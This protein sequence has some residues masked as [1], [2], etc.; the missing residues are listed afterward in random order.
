LVTVV[1]HSAT[2]AAGEWITAT[3][4][5]VND[6]NMV[7]PVKGPR[8]ET[9]AREMTMT[10]GRAAI[11]ATTYLLSI[12]T[13]LSAGV[14]L[15]TCSQSML[16]GTWQVYFTF[17][18]VCPVAIASHGSVSSGTCSIPPSTTFSLPQPPSGLLTIDRSCHVTGT[19]SYSYLDPDNGWGPPAVS[20]QLIMTL[21]RSADGS[22][23]SGS[24]LL[25]GPNYQPVY[26]PVD[27]IAE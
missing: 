21:W 15:P 12:A 22:R 5:W 26:V 8:I 2:I 10:W 17:G 20:L 24:A 23:L 4:E 7:Q 13:A 9:G 6:R 19:I 18:F 3:G 1:G 25:S 14:K 16:E 27:F 11:T